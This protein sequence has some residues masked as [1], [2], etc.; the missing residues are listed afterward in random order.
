[1][2]LPIAMSGSMLLLQLESVLMSVAYVAIANTEMS[3]AF[4][5]AMLM[6]SACF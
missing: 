3:M 6:S 1:M 5:D 2:V 4:H